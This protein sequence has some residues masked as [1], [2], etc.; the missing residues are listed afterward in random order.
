MLIRKVTKQLKNVTSVA[1]VSPAIR[2]PA[3]P[4]LTPTRC[5]YHTGHARYAPLWKFFT[6]SFY[7]FFCY[8]HSSPSPCASPTLPRYPSTDSC[9]YHRIVPSPT[10]SFLPTTP[11]VALPPPSS[12]PPARG[13][14]HILRPATGTGCRESIVRRLRLR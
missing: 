13:T 6:F 12:P 10:V 4:H 14:T 11:P 7:H 5:N 2:L 9:S 1:P 3:K 8:P